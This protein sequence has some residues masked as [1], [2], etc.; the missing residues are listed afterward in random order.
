MLWNIISRLHFSSVLSYPSYFSSSLSTITSLLTLASDAFIGQ[1][2]PGHS[3]LTSAHESQ[4]VLY[5]FVIHFPLQFWQVAIFVKGLYLSYWNLHDNFSWH[6]LQ[7][8]IVRIICCMAWEVR[9]R[10][11][12]NYFDYNQPSRVFCRIAFSFLTSF[13]ESFISLCLTYLFFVVGLLLLIPLAW[14]FPTFWVKFDAISSVTKEPHT[15]INLFSSAGDTFP[16]W[17]YAI[18]DGL[19]DWKWIGKVPAAMQCYVVN[20]HF[21]LSPSCVGLVCDLRSHI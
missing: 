9:K 1:Q 19:K 11:S 7:T 17:L 6:F 8:P 20:F 14:N 4:N 12:N 10:G 15:L 5:A 2:Q 18:K 16:H 13:S 3:S 21:Y